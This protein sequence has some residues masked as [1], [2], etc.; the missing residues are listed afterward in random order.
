MPASMRHNMHGILFTR[1]APLKLS[2][3]YL[4]VLKHIL[5]TCLFWSLQPLPE[6]Q[7]TNM[8]SLCLPLEF[9]SYTV[10]PKVSIINCVIKGSSYPPNKQRHGSEKETPGAWRQRQTCLPCCPVTQTHVHRVG[11]AI[12]PS[13]FLSSPSPSTFN[14]TQHQGLFQCVSSLYQVAKVLELQLQ[15]QS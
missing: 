9:G 11:D 5:A 14:L 10:C 12:Q 4:S 1:K 3:Q 6:V 13:H 7:E 8:C 2:I 15:Y